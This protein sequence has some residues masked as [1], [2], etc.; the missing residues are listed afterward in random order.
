MSGNPHS[1]G[2]MANLL[3]SK[4]RF[5]TVL[6][7]V[8]QSARPLF[9]LVPTM[10]C[11]MPSQRRSRLPMEVDKNCLHTFRVLCSQI[12]RKV[13]CITSLTPTIHIGITLISRLRPLMYIS[14]AEEEPLGLGVQF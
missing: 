7:P 11:C 5:I 4:L 13:G 9:T 12:R 8:R 1:T 3:V 10:A 2:R 14:V 6:K